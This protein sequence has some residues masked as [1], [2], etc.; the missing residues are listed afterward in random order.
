MAGRIMQ[1]LVCHEFG[2]PDRLKTDQLPVSRPTAKQL[3]IRAE[4][5]GI[6]CVDT[7]MYYRRFAAD[8]LQRYARQ[9]LRWMA[10]D[11]LSPLISQPDLLEDGADSLKKIINREAISKM[12]VI[13]QR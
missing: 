13:L 1:A 12:A 4:A 5:A 6:S 11:W 7:L 9:L 3:L 10:E 8:K 2:T